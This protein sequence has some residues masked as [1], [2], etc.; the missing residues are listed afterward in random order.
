MNSLLAHVD[1]VIGAAGGSPRL[2]CAEH[3]AG[4]SRSSFF[5]RRAHARV[6]G[7]ARPTRSL[8]R[9]TTRSIGLDPRRRRDRSDPGPFSVSVSRRA[10]LLASSCVR[11]LIDRR[12]AGSSVPSSSSRRAYSRCHFWRGAG[13]VVSRQA[14]REPLLAIV[15]RPATIRAAPASRGASSSWLP[16]G[17]TTS[18]WI[19]HSVLGRRAL[20]VAAST[21]PASSLPPAR[22]SRK[23]VADG[24]SRPR[25]AAASWSKPRHRPGPPAYPAVAAAL[26]IT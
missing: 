9:P 20:A 14:H 8:L 11:V 17:T 13:P 2:D 15:V 24:P 12:P 25:E 1:H 19:A 7:S 3:L 6:V 23:P 22:S 5:H 18:S 16:V 10:V 4:S 26:S 21:T